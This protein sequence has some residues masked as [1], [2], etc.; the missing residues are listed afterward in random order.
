MKSNETKIKID[1][2]VGEV[3]FPLTIPF[4]QQDH[5][6][7]IETE[8]KL[9]MRE[10]KA[11]FPNKEP[12]T[13]LAMTAYHFASYSFS[14]KERYEEESDEAERLLR[15]LSKLCG[16]EMVEDGNIPSEEFDIF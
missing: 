16:D 14:L 15:D 8:L 7:R 1:V 5:V 13:Y 10:L 12:I 9:Y 6:R 11:N 4:S 2:K 3:R